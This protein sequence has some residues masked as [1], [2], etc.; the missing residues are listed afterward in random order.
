MTSTCPHCGEHK[1][2]NILK[3][4]PNISCNACGTYLFG[5]AKGFVFLARLILML[6][7]VLAA[8]F[9]GRTFM[10]NGLGKGIS[11]LLACGIYAAGH[12]LFSFPLFYLGNLAGCRMYHPLPG[13]A[14]NPNEPP[15]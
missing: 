4:D 11:L 15:K 10:A 9:C 8:S 2:I 12:I 13:A 6:L 3:M 5:R 7:L 14:R 1:K